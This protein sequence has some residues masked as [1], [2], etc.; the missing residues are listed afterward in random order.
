MLNDIGERTLEA[1]QAAK[2]V[3]ASITSTMSDRTS[4]EKKFNALLEELRSS[5]LSDLN[6]DWEE[7]SVENQTSASSMLI[8]ISVFSMGWCILP[9]VQ[10]SVHCQYR[11]DS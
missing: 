2:R 3:L 10:T 7:L 9:T 1:D 5:V 6:K 8:F 11:K 4:T